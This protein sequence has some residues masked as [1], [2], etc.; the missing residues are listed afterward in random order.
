[1]KEVLTRL[2][3]STYIK[4]FY[5]LAPIDWYGFNCCFK[6]DKTLVPQSI[7]D[8]LNSYFLLVEGPKFSG[9]LEI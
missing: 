9:L 7:G 2:H 5:F 8:F 6:Q 1:M 3:T 4:I